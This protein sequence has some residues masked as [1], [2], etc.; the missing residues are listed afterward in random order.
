[1][2]A[3]LFDQEPAFKGR[4]AVTLHNQR[5]YIFFRHHRYV[6]EEKE[7]KVRATAAAAGAG[8][9]GKGKKAGGKGGKKKTE[10]VVQARLQELGPRFTLK[11]LSV[12]K[13]TF[14]SRHGEYEWKRN[15]DMDTSRRKFFL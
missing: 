1:M 11:L 4:R 15:G 9:A 7:V 6:F 5:D 10:Q 3:S 12:Q 14:D 8:A 2:L 13:G